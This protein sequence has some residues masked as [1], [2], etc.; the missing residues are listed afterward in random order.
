MVFGWES[1]VRVWFG[2]WKRTERSQL[3]ERRKENRVGKKG[4]GWRKRAGEIHFD[5]SWPKGSTGTTKR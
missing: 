4:K 2:G 1:V 3:G 5:L